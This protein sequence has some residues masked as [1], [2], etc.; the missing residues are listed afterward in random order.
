MT[1]LGSPQSITVSGT[2]AINDAARINQSQTLIATGAKTASPTVVDI[3]FDVAS[4]LHLFFDITATPNTAETITPSLEMISPSSSATL[5]VVSFMAITASTL[6]AAPLAGTREF[7]LSVGPWDA[8]AP[9]ESHG[10]GTAGAAS[11]TLIASNRSR[12]EAHIFN[13]STTEY[14]WVGRGQAAVVGQGVRIPSGGAWKETDVRDA[15]TLIRGG[16]A[17]AAVAWTETQTRAR[18]EHRNVRLP[19]SLRLRVTHSGAGSW[20]Y[21]VGAVAALA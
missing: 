10:A 2:A 21:S 4:G 18:T 5:A 17:D 7:V 9:L 8:D 3:P 14:V 1:Y 20:N 6:G 12:K 11:G 19:R 13:L 16:A 15:L